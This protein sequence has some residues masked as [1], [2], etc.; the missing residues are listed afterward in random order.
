MFNVVRGQSHD[1][2]CPEVYSLV[3]SKAYDRVSSRVWYVIRDG[4]YHPISRRVR[5][6][7]FDLITLQAALVDYV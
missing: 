6:R 7:V 1:W 4:I 3:A 2:A 5:D